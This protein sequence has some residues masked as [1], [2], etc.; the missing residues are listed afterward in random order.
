MVVT[1]ETER[2]F[3]RARKGEVK[4]LQDWQMIDVAKRKLRKDRNIRTWK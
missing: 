1:L 2:T 4:R 3:K